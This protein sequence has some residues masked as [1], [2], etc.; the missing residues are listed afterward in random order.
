MN[1]RG[2]IETVANVE[3]G[4]DSAKHTVTRRE[5]TPHLPFYVAFF[6]FYGVY[7]PFCPLVVRSNPLLV[8]LQSVSPGP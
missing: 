1:W 7:I 2:G 5:R 6:F 8:C 4:A 3:G